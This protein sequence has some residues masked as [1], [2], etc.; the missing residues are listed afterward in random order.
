MDFLLL[1]S[2]CLQLNLVIKVHAFQLFSVFIFLP[3]A[4]QRTVLW[5]GVHGMIFQNGNVG[6]SHI[7]EQT[8]NTP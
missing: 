6:R 8:G 1:Y 7:I 2:Y 4:H 3:F 5:K